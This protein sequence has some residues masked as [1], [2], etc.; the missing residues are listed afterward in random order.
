MTKLSRQNWTRI[1][2]NVAKAQSKIANDLLDVAEAEGNGEVAGPQEVV[3]AIEVI[4]DQLEEVQAAIPA[5][6][7][8]DEAVVE[9]PVEG[10]VEEVEAPV[11]EV[12]APVVEEEEEEEY[13]AKLK[14]QVAAL[15]KKVGVQ[16]RER[17]AQAYSELF[18]DIKVA[19]V[20][21]DEVIRSSEPISSWQGKI[22]AIENYRNETKSNPSYA[23][24]P[25][26][27]GF[28]SRSKVAK[29]RGNGLEHL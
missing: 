26:T 11:E 25:T 5:E 23:T 20:K 17:M 8:A 10:P 7:S 13:V 15:T 6:A 14:S 29:L 3:D 19:Q 12:E 9:A 16:E 1:A 24:A 4:V 27:S 28:L 18:D 2:R 21:F 22:A